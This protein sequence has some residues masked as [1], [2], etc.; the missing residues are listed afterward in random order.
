VKGVA[1]GTVSERIRFAQFPADLLAI[2]LKPDFLTEVHARELLK[3]SKFENLP[4]WLTRQQAWRPR[5]RGATASLIVLPHWRF[6]ASARAWGN[7][8][9]EVFGFK[10]KKWRPRARGATVRSLM[11]I[12][13][14]SLM[15]IPV[16]DL[17]GRVSWHS[18]G[19][20]PA[21]VRVRLQHP[22]PVATTSPHNEEKSST[23]GG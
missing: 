22:T 9:G 14:R 4:P 12:P 16:N 2:F 21:R 11:Q 18:R 17:P 3:S 5:A 13:V 15:Q 19:D 7:L 1:E 23:A 8:I 20:T 10:T 6:V